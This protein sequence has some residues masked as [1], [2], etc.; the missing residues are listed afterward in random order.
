M[1]VYSDS[2]S[3]GLAITGTSFT[4]APPSSLHPRTTWGQEDRFDVSPY[5]RARIQYLDMSGQ[6][7]SQWWSAFGES[8]ARFDTATDVLVPMDP[9]GG[10]V[11]L[12]FDLTRITNFVTF[13][14]EFTKVSDSGSAPLVPADFERLCVQVFDTSVDQTTPQLVYSQ[15]MCANRGNTSFYDDA[16]PGRWT[17]KLPA[18]NY[19]LRF[20]DEPNY[21]TENGTL[22]SN[23]KFAPEWC[24]ETGGSRAEQSMQARVLS[25]TTSSLNVTL[26]PAKQLQVTVSGVPA[27]YATS[28]TQANIV[29]GDDFGNWTGGAMATSSATAWTA[30]VTGL[31]EG[32]EYKI[33]LSF[34]RDGF[35]TRWWLVGGGTL[36]G[37]EGIVPGDQ[38]TEP[39]QPAPYLVT[40][41][42]TDG[43]PMGEDEGCVAVFPVGSTTQVAS[44][45]T[46]GQGDVPLQRLVAGN[47]R[48][49]AWT[50]D[51]DSV[52]EVG[53]FEV[54]AT[55]TMSTAWTD[56]A[57]GIA[58]TTALVGSLPVG[59][60]AAGAV[61]MPG[62]VAT[63]PP[64]PRFL[65]TI[66]QSDGTPIT[67]GAAC[68]E[69]QP[70]S[71]GTISGPE[72]TDG[73]GIA[74]IGPVAAGTYTVRVT[75]GGSPA[76]TYSVEVPA[77]SSTFTY[78][79]QTYAF[80]LA[81]TSNLS[82]SLPQGYSSATAV[83]LP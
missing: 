31:V 17:I 37:A 22:V 47:Y 25:T 49:I 52:L 13:S 39:W 6:A 35:P 66:H 33:F 76:L 67:G 12:D 20:E 80:G 62:S 69:M 2:A 43:T 4:W 65:V 55:Q 26:R 32:R 61:V 58:N 56:H 10:P 41:H 14:G 71:G 30:F 59:Y 75:N 38:L 72:C 79:S 5:M 19:R 24:C 82:G 51:G 44:N 48:V 57:V 29:V 28:D 53:E 40:L 50:A 54:T 16:Y 63:P 64:P 81:A 70:V 27:D 68:I 83:V 9:A 21:A 77:T 15:V 42:H 1:Q 73:L 23:V 11:R 7:V 60:E 78:N 74:V 45:C 18:G 46:D 3:S 8:G 34:S 36:D